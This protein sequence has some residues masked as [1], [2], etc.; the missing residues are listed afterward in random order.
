MDVEFE[1]E[2]F[3]WAARQDADWY[4]VAVPADL[5]HE[6]REMQTFRRGFGGVRVEA[7]IGGSTW[8][9]SIFPQADGRY[10]LPLKRAVREA[11]SLAFDDVVAVRLSVLDV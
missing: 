10:V 1:G 3:R 7:G 4:F 2:V 8:R 9:T 6:I 5:S 11:E